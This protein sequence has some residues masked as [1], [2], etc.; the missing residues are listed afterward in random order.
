MD[1]ERLFDL[2][3]Q[4]S[5]TTH[6]AFTDR[7]EQ[8][9]ALAA[10][11]SGVT[12]ARAAGVALVNDMLHPR[13]NVVVFHGQGGIG[14]SG[15]GSVSRHLGLGD[16]IQSG[17]D[18]V[19]GGVGI[20]GTAW[21]AG[22]LLRNGVVER[23][24]HKR[25]FRDCPY[26]EALLTETSPDK[27]RPFLPVLLAW[28]LSRYQQEHD[29][30]V[31]AFLDTWE[32]VQGPPEEPDG[33]EDVLSRLVYLMPNVLFVITGRSRL[34]WADPDRSTFLK[35]AGAQRWPQLASDALV[36]RQ[37]LVGN[38][39]PADS[40]DYLSRRILQSGHPAIPP[41][42]RDRI[43][44]ASDGM[45]LYLQLSADH[46][47]EL[48]VRGTPDPE[49]F[50]GTLPELVTRVVRDLGDMERQVLRAAALVTA[51]DRD[52]LAAG[53]P[54][55]RDADIERLLARHF[56]RGDGDGWFPSSL[57][58]S[59]RASIREHDAVSRDAWSP[60]EWHE[61]AARILDHLAAVVADDLSGTTPPERNRLVECFLEGFSLALEFDFTPAWLLDAARSLREMG[62][63]AV[64]E[65]VA[66]ME[67]DTPTT[68]RGLAVACAGMLQRGTGR[69]GDAEAAL[70][71][72]LELP[73]GQHL[74]D[75]VAL[76]RAE[77]HVRLDR[78]RDAARVLHPM[79]AAEGPYAERAGEWAAVLDQRAGRYP[80]VR[81][82]TE[83]AASS[84]NM[85]RAAV[86][87]H[88]FTA[89]AH[90]RF[91]QSQEA[92]REAYRLSVAEGHALT[93]G[94]MLEY[95]AWSSAWTDP[96]AALAI[97]DEAIEMNRRLGSPIVVAR[98][99][100][101]RALALAGT[102]PSSDVVAECEES[103]RLAKTTGRADSLHPL[104]V[105]LL[106]HCIDG[107]VPAAGAIAQLLNEM[108]RTVH[109]DVS[110]LAHWWLSSI[111]FNVAVP[112]LAP[113]E[114]L[115]DAAVVRD[116]WVAVL[117]ERRAMA[118]G[119]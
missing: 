68:A 85:R 9:E 30:D 65:H 100:A 16:Q 66:T 112:A 58:A 86:S 107:D 93:E 21:R 77:I 27:A 46:Y 22:T 38:L 29:A 39:S 88:G 115:D 28:E 113:V 32:T 24:T 3:P 89:L 117:D 50:G 6:L 43:V 23:V 79:A 64:L 108:T 87:L 5:L 37:H 1:L 67:S 84:A 2:G 40:E 54:E 13:H 8:T 69:L 20:V 103:R 71:A 49:Q 51:F 106:A 11:L 96:V 92:F 62:Q 14:K 18:A 119:R 111:D 61:A 99:S 52:L 97:A 19:L 73:M 102:A 26:F 109:R 98:A 91:A 90:G 10:A 60:R 31:V 34:G 78:D 83:A 33:L 48:L 94:L 53:V 114:W 12:E 56:V 7:V 110:W 118:K 63:W 74:H 35:Y 41:E 105:T 101:A 80:A 17:L 82:W 45:P 25:L 55:A 95:V 72:A 57:Q 75:A 116:R 44:A 59:L 4:T 15:F 81:A 70:S 36:S 47:A 104:L 76:E 42:V